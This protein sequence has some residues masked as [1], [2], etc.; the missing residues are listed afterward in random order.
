MRYETKSIIIGRKKRPN[1]D[2]E[3]YPCFVHLFNM[4]DPHESGRVPAQMLDFED[5]QRIV[6]TGLSLSYLL[7][8][9]DLVVN[10]L[11]HV[12]IEKKGP[13]IF[14]SGEQVSA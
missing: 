6:L 7:A 2:D 9:N 1:K 11:K 8:G 4:N 14:I 13:D 10:D 12:E 3:A 5:V